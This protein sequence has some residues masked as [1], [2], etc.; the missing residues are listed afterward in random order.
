MIIPFVKVRAAVHYSHKFFNSK[1][2]LITIKIYPRII[3]RRGWMGN[4]LF[5]FPPLVR[6]GVDGH[7]AKAQPEELLLFTHFNIRTTSC[8][9][10]YQ[11][12]F[13]TVTRTYRFKIM[14]PKFMPKRTHIQWCELLL[15]ILASCMH[16]WGY[17][18]FTIHITIPYH[19]YV[20]I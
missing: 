19:C 1:S 18:V 7:M 12:H 15:V 17:K 20:C 10:C 11:Y 4:N 16:A 2:P 9:T 13:I 3:Y 8:D 14:S 5:N 6:C